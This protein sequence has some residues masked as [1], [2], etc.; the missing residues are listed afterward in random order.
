LYDRDGGEPFLFDSR[1]DQRLPAV[2][3]VLG[4][5]KGHQ[6]LAVPYSRLAGRA[7]DG[8]AAVNLELAGE[9]VLVVWRSGATSA[10]DRRQIAASRNV[11]AAAAFS[12]RVAGRTL[13]F[14]A[15]GGRLTDQQTG[16]TWDQFGRATGGPLTGARL[17]PAT[18]MDSFWFD[19]AAF[20]P[21]TTIWAG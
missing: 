2:A 11:G 7:R 5:S 17:T 13:A 1:P 16:S 10:L 6:H 18:A 15:A 8:V 20:H 9:P 14:R 3:R 21:D 19:W 4:M 12:R